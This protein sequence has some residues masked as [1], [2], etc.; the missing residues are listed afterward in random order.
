MSLCLTGNPNDIKRALLKSFVIPK[1][2]FIYNCSVINFDS[3]PFPL[4]SLFIPYMV[5]SH[6]ADPIL[7]ILDAFISKIKS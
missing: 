2:M 3:T 7:G 5:Q 4:K 1:S 6:Y